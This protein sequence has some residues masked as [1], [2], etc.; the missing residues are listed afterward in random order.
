M[1]TLGTAGLF[2]LPVACCAALPLLIAVA[3]GA[4]LALW[5]AVA[6]AVVAAAV[7]GLLA[8]RALHR[9]AAPSLSSSSSPEVQPMTAAAEPVVPVEILSFGD[10]PNWKGAVELVE[11]VAGEI[12]V[13]A[14]IRVIDVPDAETAEKLRFLGSPTIRIAGTDIEPGAEMRADFALSCRLYRTEAGLRGQPEESWV[15][16][17]LA[18]GSRR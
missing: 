14:A 12:G 13:Q 8:I 2:M 15:R 17:A 1:K 3:S 16:A 10:C 11:R 7:A 6:F 9:R 5:G 18:D 4:A